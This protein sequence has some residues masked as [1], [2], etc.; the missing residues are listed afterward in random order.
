MCNTCRSLTKKGPLELVACFGHM[1]GFVSPL[2]T[3]F[4]LS[5]N[6]AHLVLDMKTRNL[7]RMLPIKN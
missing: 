1:V 4:L 7:T 6:K 3:F 5:I 2:R